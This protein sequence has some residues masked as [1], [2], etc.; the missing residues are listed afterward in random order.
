MKSDE[1]TLSK[2]ASIA[3]IELADI[4]QLLADLPSRIDGVVTRQ[5]AKMPEGEAL[6]EQERAWTFAD[7]ALATAEVAR[8]LAESAVRPGDRVLVVG[9]N[10]AALVA[11]LFGIARL[12]AWPV[13]VNARLSAREIDAI[14]G[15][16]SPRRT[17]YLAHVSVEAAAHAARHR[18]TDPFVV[19]TMG[20]LLMGPL[21]D[22]CL[23]EPSPTDPAMHVGALIYTTGTTGDPKGVMLTHRNLLFVAKVSSALRRLGPGDRV[24]GALPISHVYGLASVCLGTLYAGACLQLEAR[25]TPKAFAH[26]LAHCGLTVAQGVPAMYVRLLK[27]LETTG[28]PFAA[29]QLRFVYAGG[30]PLDVAL[31]AD[32]ERL[33]GLTLHNGYGLTETAP[34][35]TQTRLDAP[36]RDC[37]VG[38]ALPGVEIRVVDAVSRAVA[39]GES[40]ELWVRGPNVMRGYY[41]NEPLTART[42]DPD[43]WLNTGDMARIESD[44]AVFIVGRTKELIIRSGFNVYP[45]EVEAVLNAHPAVTHSAVVG[46]AAEDNEEVVAFVELATGREASV[47]ELARF[48][49]DRLAP[50]KRPTEIV[51]LAALPASTTGKILKHQLRM[52]AQTRAPA[53]RAR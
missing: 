26:A 9:E 8:Q 37:S 36:R 21:D 3:D 14:R 33:T 42:I 30:S 29:P 19:H 2:T 24:Y 7:L 49:Q 35:V 1:R 38:T 15:H 34:T 25:F 50:Y 27:H 32:V 31:K 16:C 52:M 10:C 39:A 17:L 22:E 43:G 53:G 4:P 45:G 40:G 28:E 51:I 41:R 18:A 12:D 47:E 13:L 6:R 23:P 11:L 48:A 5:A 46:R 20:N 44:G